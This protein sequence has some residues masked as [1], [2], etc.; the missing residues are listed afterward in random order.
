VNAPALR[1]GDSVSLR[2]KTDAGV[3]SLRSAIEW[4]DNNRVCVAWPT[5]D[6]RLFPLHAGQRVTVEVSHAGDALYILDTLLESA[7]TEEPPQLV[8]KATSDWQRLQRRRTLRYAIDMRPT[9][10]LLRRA[11]GETQ[12]L[13]AI[14]TDLS[15]GGLRL[16]SDVEVAP[17]DT[18]E[19][20]FATPSGGAELRLRVNVLRVTPVTRTRPLW[21]AGCEFVE[22]QAA[23]RDQIV[24]FI[25]AQQ[26]ASQHSGDRAPYQL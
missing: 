16:L 21:E 8:L 17:S 13:S 4:T 26:S 7:S 2:V 22:P 11:S 24:Q 12:G 14:I 23:E 9:A 5:P 25:L 3:H 20:A 10:A 19:L 1:A 15:S 18:V 6:A